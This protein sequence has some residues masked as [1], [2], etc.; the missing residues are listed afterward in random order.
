MPPRILDELMAGTTA[1]AIGA[2]TIADAMRAGAVVKAVTS[3]GLAA[4]TFITVAGVGV[5]S[6]TPA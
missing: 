4:G 5:E 6:G 2:G 1:G 3:V